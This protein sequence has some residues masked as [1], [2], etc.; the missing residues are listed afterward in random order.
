M[1]K[2]SSE[3][4]SR[5]AYVYVRQSTLDQVQNNLESQR[6]QYGL[7]D[8]AREL[9]WHEV[10]VVDDDLG[11]S[12]SGIRRPG[13]EKLLSA[14]CQGAVGAVFSIEASRLARN[15]RDWHT[16]LEFCRLVDALL[17]D[18][19]GIYNPREPNDRL[20]LGMKGTISEMELSTFRQRSQAALEQMAG[21][22]ELFTSIAVGYVRTAGNRIERDPD[23]R[24]RQAID[25]VFKKFTETHSVRQVLLW[26]RQERIEMPVIRH[27]E[28]K[29]CVHWKLPVYNT[30]LKLFTNP[31][32]AGA[33][34]HGRTK[35]VTRIS[36]GRK[37]I[38]RN[39]KV[40]LRDWRTL[41]KQHHEGYIT[42]DEYESNQLLIAHNANMKGA[43]VRGSVKRGDALLAGLLRCG[44][45][46][47]K[48]H[49]MYSG[50]G[51]GNVRY[52]CRGANVNHGE[53]VCISFGGLRPDAQVS[54]EVLHR[55]RPL[56][57]K[58][59]LQAIELTRGQHNARVEHRR[60]ALQQAEYEV[61]HAR[62]QYDAVDP[63]NRLVVSELERR[64]NLALE[65]RARQLRELEEVQRTLPELP[66][67]SQRQELLRLGEN[68]P[69]LWNHP[70]AS[71]E[72]KK[73][74]LRAVLNEI[75]V[76]VDD[77]H[78]HMVLHWQGGDHTQLDFAKNKTG[79][80][81]FQTDRDVVDLVTELAR[82]LSD[83]HIA[84]LLNRLGKRTAHGHSW[85]R[86]RVCILRNDRNIAVYREGERLERGELTLEDCAKRLGMSTMSV[87]RLIKRGQL[88]ARQ[89][90][91]GAPWVVRESD[92][93]LASVRTGVH[94]GPST[95][96]DGQLGIEFQ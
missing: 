82:V 61:V 47:R 84:S 39:C 96:N 48:L 40:P 25:L 45:C 30:V 49:V 2:I 3:H 17:I 88:A 95:A 93:E 59:A 81:R 42:W 66:S 36:N 37:Q 34:A 16:L 11:R 60:L 27:L 10:V 46:G 4:L 77:G 71:A 22:G 65:T 68:L 76:K 78:I 28:Q 1:N 52:S 63:A 44:H 62:R 18:E 67:E 57:I 69:L 5:A 7:A 13:F 55:L 50:A 15:G 53:G 35:S 29:R 6:L 87:A 8:R 56:G 32:Y 73:H 21:R 94:P 19:N 12:A 54:A 9:G 24:V 33:Y 58:A 51:A 92:L 85:T 31:I 20:L 79:H 72:I 90:C 26:L 91:R 70:N 41:L 89:A 38:T 14:L 83:A 75:V 64:W 80:H 43:M 86:N 74:I 23:A